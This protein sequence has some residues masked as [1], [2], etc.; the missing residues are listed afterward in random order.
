MKPPMNGHRFVERRVEIVLQHWCPRMPKIE[1]GMPRQLGRS[2]Q[3]QLVA[4][5]NVLDNARDASAAPLEQCV[6][7]MTAVAKYQA[8]LDVHGVQ[9]VRPEPHSGAYHAHET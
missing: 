4:R 7:S 2:H 3:F 8:V 5:T 9:K 6:R 1:V